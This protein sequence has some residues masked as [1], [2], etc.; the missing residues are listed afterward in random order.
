[1]TRDYKR[2]ATEEAFMA[3]MVRDLYR[4]SVDAGDISDPGFLSM[5]GFLFAGES[6]VMDGLLDI[7]PLRLSEM[8]KAGIDMHL[9]S[10][11]APGLQMLDRDTAVGAMPELN[12]YLAEAIA[13][14]PTRFS[15]LCSIAPQDPAA[16][17]REIERC[18]T[19]LGLN[20]IMIN[21]HTNGEWLD[22]EKFWPIFE[23]AE[24][25]DMT[26]YIH[27]QTPRPSLSE[28]LNQ[29]MEL[30]F[31]GFAVE[32]STHMLAIIASGALDRFPKLRFVLGHLGEGLPYWLYRFDYMQKNLT[33]PGIAAPAGAGR[34]RAQDLRLHPP[35]RLGD[36]QRHARARAD[37]LRPEADRRGPR[38]LRD[39][40]SLSERGVRGRPER[41]SA[42][43]R[44]P[45]GVLGGY[46]AEAVPYR[47]ESGGLN[48]LSSLS[49][50]AMGRGT[51]RRVVEGLFAPVAP[52]PRYAR[53]PS[54]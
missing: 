12:D 13:R 53:S 37:P 31:Y 54:P 20:G 23:A 15:G 14:H 8:D 42:D 2:I 35:Q 5:W 24:A 51:T 33:R 52:P 29:G 40:L 10:Q 30:A 16:S 11:T 41:G 27:P 28:F 50:K 19:R 49:P 38:P 4:K 17:A 45:Q 48:S 46:G 25:A 6:P 22:Q 3:P 44:Q 18:R 1:M 47:R 34:A 32:V 43:R 7:G 9:L 36:D 21:S 39:G 26:I